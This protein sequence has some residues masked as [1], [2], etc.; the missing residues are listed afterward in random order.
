MQERG[1]D[2]DTLA[3]GL[4]SQFYRDSWKFSTDFAY[5][6]SSAP[7]KTNTLVAHAVNPNYNDAIDIYDPNHSEPEAV[8]A[9]KDYSHALPSTNVSVDFANVFL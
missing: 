8:T 5:L 3:L 7:P 1:Q 9:N 6:K 4:N 2:S